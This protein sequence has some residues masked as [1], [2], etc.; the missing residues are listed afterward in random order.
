M[1]TSAADRA[2]EHLREALLSGEHEPGTMLS[3]AT[4]AAE[5]GVSRTPVRAALRR[6]QDDGLVVIYPKRGALVRELSLDEVRQYAQ[7]RH[8]LETAGVQFAGPEA[9]ATLRTELTGNLAAQERALAE[10]DWS[11]FA[12]T[13]VAF[14]RAFA[15]LSGNPV[16]LDYYDRL[17]DRQLLSI[18]RSRPTL[19]DQPEQVLDEHRRLLDAAEAGDWAGFATQLRSHQEQR[20][21]LP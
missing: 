21:R 14:H 1:S 20:H 5:L 11:A 4:V 3:E 13:A 7:M 18:L 10:A 19:V 8:A 17:R 2:L 12:R 6:L 15:K 16:M 9:R